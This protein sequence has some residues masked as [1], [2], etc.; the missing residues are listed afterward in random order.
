MKVFP[1]L[2]GQ[3]KS[4]MEL[5]DL[6]LRYAQAINDAEHRA[7]PT[8]DRPTGADLRPGRMY[9]DTTLGKPVWYDGADW[10]DAT[11]A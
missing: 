8:T 5:A 9:F 7:G 1:P 10:V 11:G 6:L 3:V 4:E 2:A